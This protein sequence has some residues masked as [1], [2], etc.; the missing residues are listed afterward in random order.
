MNAFTES[1]IEEAAL[2]WLEVVGWRI[3][4][5]P[6]IASYSIDMFPK[7]FAATFMHPIQPLWAAVSQ[8]F[9]NLRLSPHFATLYYESSS[10]VGHA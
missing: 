7:L 6:D 9:T 2:A 1:F 5:G 4:H 3:V 10:S 8:L